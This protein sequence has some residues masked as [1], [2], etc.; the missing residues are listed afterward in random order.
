MEICSLIGDLLMIFLAL[1]RSKI[2]GF[3]WLYIVESIIRCYILCV[4]LLGCIFGGWVWAVELDVCIF[5][6]GFDSILG[7]QEFLWTVAI[8]V[9]VD[10]DC[11]CK[12]FWWLL[13]LLYKGQILYVGGINFIC[14]F[15][16]L[17]WFISESVL[18]SNPV[19][20]NTGLLLCEF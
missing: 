3:W 16:I 15:L 4:Y 2:Q 11:E 5:N 17:P 7:Y 6:R 20:A 18:L 10:I 9:L 14:V 12:T 13:M 1:L 19:L 8:S